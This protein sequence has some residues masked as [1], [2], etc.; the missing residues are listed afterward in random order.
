MSVQESIQK[1]LDEIKKQ[2]PKFHHFCTISE[3]ALSRAK[4][5]EKQKKKGKLYGIS[6]SVKDAICVKGLVSRAGS[7]ILSGYKPV[8]NATVI[9]RVQAE[10][11]G[12]VGKT[13]QD[14][15]G[16]GSFSVNVGLG[17]EIPKNPHD[18]SR[19]TGGS[20]GG[21]AGW[22]ALTKN[23]HASIAESTGGSIACPASFCGVAG[24]TPTYG[25]VSR[26]GLMDYASSLDKIG[27]MGKTMKEAALLLEVISGADGKDATALSQKVPAFSTFAGKSVNG[28]KVGVVKELMGEG[29]DR[30]VKKTVQK[31]LD[32][33]EKLGAIVETVS[34]PLSAKYAVPAYYLIA[35]AEAS[36]NLAK[37]C[38]MRYGFEPE[39]K[40]TFD[41]Y[42]S[43]VRST[44]LGKEAKRRIILGTFAR[45]SGYRDAYY[46]RALKVRSKIIQEFQQQFKK[47]DVLAHPTMPFI[48]PKFKEI[49]KLSPLQNY[50]ADICTVPS[51]LGGF[52]HV[53]VNAGFSKGMP[54]GIMF[55]SDHFEEGKSIQ[56]SSAVE[57]VKL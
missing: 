52:P 37:Y 29:I 49:E 27:T 1:S 19:C 26:Y 56:A 25:R 21:S 47:F 23:A 20:S 54:V 31:K 11:G 14:E 6:I 57:K 51:N 48:A 53:S 17:F 32:E 39:L 50:L 4:I 30:D 22:T 33:L 38:G 45:M 24:I 2:N 35:T 43:E 46:L 18:V 8:F 34:L 9:D 15:F 40:G 41:E 36:T 10:G 12:V 44:A 13:S 28:L 3:Q 7:K 5:L 55:S 42:F 16:F